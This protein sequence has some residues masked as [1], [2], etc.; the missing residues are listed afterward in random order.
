MEQRKGKGKKGKEIRVNGSG[1]GG[2]KM[3][4]LQ[5]TDNKKRERNKRGKGRKVKGSGEGQRANEEQ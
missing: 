5:R 2:R 1:R 4:K 3:E